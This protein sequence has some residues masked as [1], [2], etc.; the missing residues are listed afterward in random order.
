MLTPS[1]CRGRGLIFTRQ[2]DELRKSL[3]SA[4]KAYQGALSLG[5]RGYL[6]GRG[7]GNE[8]IARYR[9]GVVDGSVADHN[10]YSGMISIPYLTRL[11]GVN[12][13]KFR[14][15]HECKPDCAHQKYLT[16]YP[17]RIYNPAAFD[18]A[19]KLGYIA[20]S[21]GEFDAMVL[22]LYC[23]IP[24][25]GIPGVNTWTKHPEWKEL[26]R[27]YSRVLMFADNDDPGRELSRAITR[28]CDNAHLISL[29]SG[30]DVTDAFRATGRDTI[31]KEANV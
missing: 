23:G 3:D 5:A 25:V 4:T 26:F 8:A 12:G 24:A 17:T 2:S 22:D 15:A 28:D 20:I 27:G 1:S 21:E 19:D 13:L 29:A 7:I 18:Q 9:L 30:N 10:D 31:R 6:H 16:P 14:Q 11:G